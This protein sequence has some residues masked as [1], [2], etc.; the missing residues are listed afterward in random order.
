MI[1]L[2]LAVN[3]AIVQLRCQKACFCRMVIVIK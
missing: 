1:T 3:A 2:H